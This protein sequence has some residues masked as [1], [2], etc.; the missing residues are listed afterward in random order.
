M[1]KLKMD[2]TEGGITMIYCCDEH[3]NIALDQIVDEYEVAPDFK[4]L[5]SG[6]ELSTTCEYC[7]KDATYL[8]T[9]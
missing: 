6:M 8:V 2:I 3:I 1:G 5:T 9:N 7:T 4:K